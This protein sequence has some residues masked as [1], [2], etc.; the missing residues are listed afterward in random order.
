MKGSQPLVELIPDPPKLLHS[1]DDR[2]LKFEMV[3]HT[4]TRMIAKGS[5]WVKVAGFHYKRC[6]FLWAGV[7]LYEYQGKE[8]VL[9]LV[10]YNVPNRTF[11]KP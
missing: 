6:S 2:E 1:F 3:K 7:T 4:D 5:N 8:W 10:Q 9:Q 11:H